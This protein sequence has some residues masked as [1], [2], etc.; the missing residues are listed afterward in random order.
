M[1]I[2]PE[3]ALAWRKGNDSNHEVDGRRSHGRATKERDRD[4]R[5]HLKWTLVLGALAAIAIAGAAI[6]KP[7]VV[8]AGN[9]VLRF[10][11]SISPTALSKT[12]LTP[13][14]FK[15]SAN[16][17]TKDGKHPPAAKTFMA[18]V[19]KNGALNPKGLPVCK[20]GQLEARTTEAALAACEGA[21]IGKGSAEAEVEFA[22]QAPFDAKG[23]LLV[24]NG[25]GTPSKTLILIHVYA[26]VPAPTAFITR[27]SVTKVSNGKYGLK[28]DSKIP[29]VAGGAG[30]LTKFSITNRKIFTYKGKKQSYF[31]AKCPTGSLFGQG[32]ATFTDGTRLRGTVSLPCTPKG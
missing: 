12:K 10:D 30:S 29:V 14:T 19:D 28:V 26:N 21:L 9:L 1:F 23:P 15:L 11:S 32:E 5:K 13:I 17:S 6:A 25:G 22:E 31:L 24:F 7:T 8:T 4:M 2:E 20:Q 16:V 18:E 3:N 27:V